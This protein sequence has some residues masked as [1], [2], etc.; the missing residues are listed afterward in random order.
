MTPE[1]R[2]RA[3]ERS[4]ANE[5]CPFARV[6]SSMDSN[7]PVLSLE[8]VCDAAASEDGNWRCTFRQQHHGSQLV[9]LPKEKEARRGSAELHVWPRYSMAALVQ[10]QRTSHTSSVVYNDER[11][12]SPLLS[13]TPLI[14]LEA[15]G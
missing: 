2:P 6:T 1:Q 11:G 15:N 7:C 9:R 5:K 14:R 10:E 13:L 8:K 4:V 3:S 12:S